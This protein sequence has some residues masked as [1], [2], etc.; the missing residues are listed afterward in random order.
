MPTVNFGTFTKRKNSTKRPTSELSDVR[1]VKL[2]QSTSYDNPTFIITGDVSS[3]NYCSWNGCYYFV[4]DIRSMHNGLTE[5][6]AEIDVLATYKTNILNTVAYVAYDS[7]ANTELVDNR[8]PMKT[9]K[10]VQT[11]TAACPLTLDGGCYILSITG[12]EDSTGVYKVTENELAALIDDLQNILD[13]IFDV[14]NNPPAQPTYSGSDWIANFVTAFEY[15]A[16]DLKWRL[17][18]FRKPISQI[19]GSGNI[20][21]NIRECRF[22]PFNVGTTVPRPTDPDTGLPKNV[23]LGT[24][25]TAITLS[26]LA[27]D[28]VVRS[29]TVSIPWQANDYRRR[30][31]YTELYLYL[32]YIGMVRLSTENLTGITTL[33]VDYALS[34]RDGSLICTVSGC[35]EVIGQYSGNVGISVPVGISNLS[36]PKVAQSVLTGIGALAT[37]NIGVIGMSALNFADSVTPNYTCVGG[38]D[39]LAGVAT[40]Q[41]ITCYSVFHDTIAAPNQNLQVIGSPSMCSK[42]LS[43]LTGFVQ[44]IDA[45]VEAP[46]MSHELD[47][48][49]NYLNSGF[50]IE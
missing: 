15:F 12:A 25:E 49:D 48:I 38:L 17:D 41:N 14:F 8:L 36:A 3:Y 26:K 39:G 22:I 13:N 30:S 11:A 16:D 46:A 32:P 50:F 20:P 24:F 37:K 31:P 19:F 35:G 23:Y 29:A 33:N 28:T 18:C 40:N 4:T 43:T 34:V 2:K 9:T 47:A 45:H 5:I 21:Q 44:C 10:T 42:S 27:T 7:V 1:D 6:D